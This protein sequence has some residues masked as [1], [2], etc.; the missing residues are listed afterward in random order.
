MSVCILSGWMNIWKI[1]EERFKHTVE[2]DG[3]R[4]NAVRI[5]TRVIEKNIELLQRHRWEM[6]F[7]SHMNET[8]VYKQAC[9]PINTQTINSFQLRT[10][11]ETI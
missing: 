10:V 7:H 8:E 2:V 3:S 9:V 4:K 1:N 5:Y 6:D 11:R